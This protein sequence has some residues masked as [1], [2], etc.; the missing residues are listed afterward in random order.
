[1]AEPWAD[2]PAGVSAQAGQVLRK[3]DEARELYHRLILMV[4]PAGS[5]KTN[6]LNAIIDKRSENLDALQLGYYYE[7]LKRGMEC[8]NQRAIISSSRSWNSWSTR[9]QDKNSA[10]VPVTARYRGERSQWKYLN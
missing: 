4:G 2:L 5:G 3:I 7:A 8:A 9:R 1:M 10:I 6:D